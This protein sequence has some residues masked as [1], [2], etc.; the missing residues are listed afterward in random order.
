[1]S[2]G[3]QPTMISPFFAK[4]IVAW[5][6]RY[7]QGLRGRLDGYEESFRRGPTSISFFPSRLDYYDLRLSTHP[8]GLLFGF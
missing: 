3:E 1:V 6:K 4:R 5:L 2:R 7:R 8:C